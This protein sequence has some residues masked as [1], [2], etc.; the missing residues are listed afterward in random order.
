MF[1]ILKVKSFK[2]REKELNKYKNKLRKI[3]SILIITGNKESTLTEN[4]NYKK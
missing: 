3:N 4:K 1:K 2:K